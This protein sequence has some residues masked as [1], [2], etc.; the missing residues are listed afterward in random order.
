MMRSSLRW[1]PAPCPQEIAIPPASDDAHQF[2][3]GTP[4]V[5]SVT[6][7]ISGRSGSEAEQM[8]RGEIL[9]RPEKASWA[10][11]GRIDG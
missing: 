1:R 8:K 9:S 2:M 11:S 6:A 7:R 3:T 5:S 10:R 4:H